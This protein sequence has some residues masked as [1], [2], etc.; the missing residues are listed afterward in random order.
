MAGLIA[1]E[2]AEKS[3]TIALAA[4]ADAFRSMHHAPPMLILP[5]A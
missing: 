5:N 4:K 3:M 2:H 1:M